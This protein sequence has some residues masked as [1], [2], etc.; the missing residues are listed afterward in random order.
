MVQRRIFMAPLLRLD[1]SMQRAGDLPGAAC[2]VL[3]SGDAP[4]H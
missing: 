3:P 1:G 2:R 4:R